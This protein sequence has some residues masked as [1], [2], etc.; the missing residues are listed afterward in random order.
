MLNILVY[1]EGSIFIV[2]CFCIGTV[3]YFMEYPLNDK[4]FKKEENNQNQLSQFFLINR[5]TK[6]RRLE[7]KASQ[8]DLKI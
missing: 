2:N 8:T 5:Q 4:Y 3:F 6:S 7:C 1:T